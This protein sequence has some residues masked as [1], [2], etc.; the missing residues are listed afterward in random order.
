MERTILHVDMNNF[1]ASVE[2]LSHPELIDKPVAV[3]GD[4]SARHGIILAKNYVARK[5][6]VQTGEAIW[7]AQQKCPNLVLLSPHYDLYVQISAYAR[8]IYENYTDLVESFGIDEAWL[9]VSG[10]M[11]LFDSGEL[12]AKEI[13]MRIKKEIGITASAGISWNKVFAKLGSDM[14][15]PDAYT[16]I[17]QKNYRTN[18][19]NLPLDALL[20]VG[21]SNRRM[22]AKYGINTIGALA[23]CD[24]TSIEKIAGKNGV[25]LW[26][27]ANGLDN[28]PVVPSYAQP[29][30]KSIGNSMTTPRDLSNRDDVRMV[31]IAL[32]EQVG[33]RLRAQKLKGSTLAIHVRESSSLLR[34]YERQCRLTRPSNITKELADTAQHLFDTSYHWLVPVRSI[35]LR[36]TDLSCGDLPEQLNLFTDENKRVKL[37]KLDSTMDKLQEKY[38]SKVLRH[39]T[40]FCENWS[41]HIGD[42][43]RDIL[44]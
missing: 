36:L 24:C 1:F 14:K 27:N 19:W 31:F 41:C 7:K 4:K 10:S 9:D 3:V 20:Y 42:Q 33:S 11:R 12:V 22:F 38:G 16:K 44:H 6:G 39:A 37:E 35:G 25:T 13:L 32:A 8:K 5:F 34:T 28:S 21:P 29:I 26:N 2:L 18:V 17:T 43:A 23:N 40:V 30:V 15:K